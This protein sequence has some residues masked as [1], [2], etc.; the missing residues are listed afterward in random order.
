MA[1]KNNIMG[2]NSLETTGSVRFERYNDFGNTTR[3]KVG[4]NYKPLDFLMIRASFNEGFSA[5][6]LP[7]V[8]YGTQF[9]VDTQPGTPD[10]YRSGPT[11]I[12]SYV[13]QN[14]TKAVT[15]LKPS[16]SIGKSVGAVLDV[17]YIK[18]LKGLSFTADYWQINQANLIGTNPSSSS[19]IMQSDQTALTNYTQQQLAAG[20]NINAI[21]AGS[22]T[23][24][25]QGSPNVVRYA[26]TAT[27]IQQF[28]AYNASQPPSKQE[29]VVGAVDY[30]IQTYQNLA[31]GYSDGWDLGMNYDFPKTPWGK[32]S[33]NQEWS[34]Q[35]RNYT[36]AP[37][38]TGG[39][40]VTDNMNLAGVTRW[41]GT[42][43]LTWRLGQWEADI[44][45]YYIGKYQDSSA[46]VT[47]AQYAAL[48]DPSYI[49]KQYSG[50]TVTY[51]EVIQDTLNYNVGV[52]YRFDHTASMFV[53]DTTFRVGVI[54]L[55]DEKP[56]LSSGQYGFDTS[57]Y[58]QLAIGRD[59]TFELTRHF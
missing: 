56:P 41:R 27:D 24:G 8:N 32:F 15:G 53:R 26:P 5:P 22:G 49:E 16:T 17:P 2:V 51:R 46:T 6:A 44:G 36:N 14:E 59:F 30:R 18:L 28:A 37:V 42:A 3:P 21:N 52:S 9:S 35:M 19:I 57:V 48:N 39:T 58:N 55:L 47:A 7:L 50:G 13:A 12:S 1:P 20:V 11:G 10:P 38:A 34:Y 25:Y 29:A 40:I 43:T 31:Q 54:N 33:F 23:T 4:L 45:A